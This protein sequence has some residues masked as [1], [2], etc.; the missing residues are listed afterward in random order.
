MAT[1]ANAIAAYANAGK[2]TA[3]PGLETPAASSGTGFADILKSAAGDALGALK[4]GEAES[5]KAVTGKADLNAV[6]QAVGNAEVALQAVVAVR[7]RVIQAY[8]DITKMPI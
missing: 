6:T 3:T 4:S 1:I 7:D 5:L 8:Q 2:V